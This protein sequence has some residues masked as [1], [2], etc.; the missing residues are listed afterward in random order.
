M[1]IELKAREFAIEAHKGQVRKS[2]PE[3]P[4]IVHPI[5]VAQI[6]IFSMPDII[7]IIPLDN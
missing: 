6:L 1:S 7:P 3:K 5:N 4:M 2:D